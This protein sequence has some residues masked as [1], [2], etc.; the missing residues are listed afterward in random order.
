LNELIT[1]IQ[2][3]QAKRNEYKIDEPL[4]VSIFHTKSPHKNP[5]TTTN[6]KFINFQILIDCICRMK[7]NSDD[8]EE[9]IT[10]C[11]D[12][13]K[14]NESELN[15][16]QQFEEKYSPDRAVYWLT[17]E[18]FVCRMLN[19]AFQVKNIDLL[20]FFRFFIRDIRRQLKDNKPSAPIR[21]YRAQLMSKEE[22]QILQRSIGE[23]ISINTFLSTIPDRERALSI[24]QESDAS[25]DMMRVLIEID[26][27]PRLHGIKPFSDITLMNYFT[28]MEVILFM[29]GSIFRPTDIQKENNVFIIQMEACSDND[30]KLKTTLEAVKSECY[31]GETN[32]LSF[33][34]ILAKMKK[35]DDAE[36]Y[37]RRFL[38]EM[39]ND[40]HSIARCYEGLGN[41]AAE[42]RDYD[43]ALQSYNKVLEV[44]R[45]ILRPDDPEIA[46]SYNNIAGIYLKK[47]EYTEAL[48]SY[49]L[50]LQIWVRAL[51]Q[52]HAKV[53]MCYKSIG[54][55]YENDNQYKEALV[56]YQKALTIRE[57]HLAAE[58]PDLGKLNST[59]ANVYG[60]MGDTNK[61]LKHYTIALKIFTKAYSN[62]NLEVALTY[63]NIGLAHEA[64]GHFNQALTNIQK[65]SAIRHQL[66]PANHPD[67]VRIDQDIKRISTRLE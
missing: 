10:L 16:V 27:D 31:H 5:S 64:A 32:L 65:A 58:H 3:D 62:H 49:T 57:R 6:D 37:Y 63:K 20:F 45:H 43:L 7:W 66:L 41:I 35:F 21:T 40:H 22:M 30:Q 46:S 42:K 11:E 38:D 54:S 15:V 9:L 4:P 44:N 13:Y 52:D 8:L 12:E 60:S 34:Y 39:P 1:Q 2:T 61:A 47:E 14:G 36:K 24:L 67:I 55:V 53:G 56:N 23:L 26:A 33:G 25:T 59:I 19:K 17:R 18:S 50:A 48:E 29:A 51:G 28:G